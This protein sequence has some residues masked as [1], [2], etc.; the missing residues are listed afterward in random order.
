MA[1]HP[2]PPLPSL[3]PRLPDGAR[4]RDHGIPAIEAGTPA[5]TAE[6]PPLVLTRGQSFHGYLRRGTVLHVRQGTA[7]LT[8]AARWLAASVWRTAVSLT[9]GQVHV[10]ETSGWITLTSDAGARI[11]YRDDSADARPHPA[12]R[13]VG[14]ALR[15]R[16]GF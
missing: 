9:A 13:T 6:A 3:A 1:K 5:R 7:T 12:R 15:A 10:L 2:T 4:T 11:G 8:P 14:Q 16:F